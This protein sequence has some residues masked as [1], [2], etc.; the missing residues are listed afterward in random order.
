MNNDDLAVRRRRAGYRATHRGS[1]EMDLT[2]GRF[3]EAKLG[4]MSGAQLAAF[5]RLLALPDPDLQEMVWHPEACGTGEFAELI[6]EL[7]AFHGLGTVEV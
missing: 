7:R 5:E 3:A 2:L 4:S 1:K 6:A